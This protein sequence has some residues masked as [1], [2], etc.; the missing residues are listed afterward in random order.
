MVSPRCAEALRVGDDGALGGF[1]AGV[2]GSEPAG[3]GGRLWSCECEAALAEELRREELL[4]AEGHLILHEV[5][6]F[7]VVGVDVGCDGE[8]GELSME[9]GAVLITGGAGV[10]AVIGRGRA[11]RPS[12]C[13]R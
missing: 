12:A 8:V 1:H 7:P 6:A 3:D 4:R 9:V 11:A 5:M 10:A 13:G 2:A